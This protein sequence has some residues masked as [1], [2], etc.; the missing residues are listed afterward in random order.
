MRIL[1][2]DDERG[3]RKLLASMLKT[4]GFEVIEAADGDEAWAILRAPDAPRLAILDWMMPGMTG[5]D[6]I[7]GTRSLDDGDTFYLLLLTGMKEQEHIN[8]GLE[9]GADDYITKPYHREELQRRLDA[10]R[11][12]VTLQESLRNKLVELQGPWTISR[13]CR[14]SFPSACTATRSAMIRTPGT[15]WRATSSSTREPSSATDSAPIAWK[16]ITPRKKKKR[17]RP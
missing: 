3:S 5:P 16:S 15:R 7:Y 8:M 4:R 17:T 6:V 10:G 13:P 1:I 9:C 12:I 2:A 14:E 11:R